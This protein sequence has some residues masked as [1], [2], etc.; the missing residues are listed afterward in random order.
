MSD[1]PCNRCT[2]NRLAKE[3]IKRGETA[4]LVVDNHPGLGNGGRRLVYV[5]KDGTE[6]DG[7]HWF[8]EV[9]PSCSC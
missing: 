9:T 3:A 7:G 1:R 2:F 6:R 5:A 4:K 8:M